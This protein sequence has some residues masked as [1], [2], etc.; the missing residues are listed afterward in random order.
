MIRLSCIIAIIWAATTVY[1]QDLQLVTDIGTSA[2]MVGI[3]HIEGFDSTAAGLFENPASLIHW[4]PVS[5]SL[6]LTRTLQDVNYGNVAV[7]FKLPVGNLAIGLMEASVG[8]L[9]VTFRNSIGRV[10]QAGTFAFRSLISKV[11]YQWPVLDSLHA[12]IGFNY[13]YS[14]AYTSYANG[15]NADF[16]LFSEIGDWRFSSVL[17]N[18]LANQR[19]TYSSGGDATIPGK[20][21]VSGS[22]AQDRLEWYGQLEASRLTDFLKAVGLRY[23]VAKRHRYLFVSTGIR[24]FYINDVKRLEVPVGLGLELD[25][26]SLYVAYSRA[27]YIDDPNHYYF[28]LS[29]DL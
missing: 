28:S 23:Y 1:S 26:L 4:H 24:E 27:D 9:P 14:D 8:G 16:G 12:G 21:M 25:A 11:A 22:Y 20:W 13:Y 19:L 15:W 3:G 18:V 10:D 29:A 5:A 2:Q 7:Q 6:F 17:K